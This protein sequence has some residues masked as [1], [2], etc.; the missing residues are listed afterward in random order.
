M[1]QTVSTKLQRIAQ[2]GSKVMR[3]RCNESLI[4]EEPY[5]LIGQ[6]RV[7]GGAVG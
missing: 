4:T 7:C 1:L 5:G 2:E 6:V 3:Q